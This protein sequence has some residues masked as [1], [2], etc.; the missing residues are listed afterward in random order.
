MAPLSDLTKKD[1]DFLWTAIHECAFLILKKMMVAPILQA[2][3]WTLL[4]HV[5]VDA[6]DVVVGAVLMQEASKG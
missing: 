4:F 6:L 3:N 1:V 5:F 2:P